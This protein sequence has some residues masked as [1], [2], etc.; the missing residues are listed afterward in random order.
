MLNK[1][2][3]LCQ[4]PNIVYVKNLLAR[5]GR[6]LFFILMNWSEDEEANSVKR[7]FVAARALRAG[8]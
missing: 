6:K 3:K 7:V 4:T 1:R 5:A 2:E 8:A